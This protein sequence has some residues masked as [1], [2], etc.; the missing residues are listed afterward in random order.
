MEKF[1]GLTVQEEQA[2][3]ALTDEQKGLIAAN[4]RAIKNEFLRAPPGITHGSVKSH[5]KFKSYMKAVHIATS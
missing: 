5:D 4:D 1:K 2:L 3:L